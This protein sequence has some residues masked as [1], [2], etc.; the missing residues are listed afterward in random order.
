M[1]AETVWRQWGMPPAVLPDAFLVRDVKVLHILPPAD[2]K[3]HELS[4]F[5][6]ECT[7]GFIY[8]SLC[9]LGGSSGKVLLQSLSYARTVLTASI[10]TDR[11][12]KLGITLSKL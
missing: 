9:S 10:S 3:P 6:R 12:T 11:G 2:T 7:R 8:P 1:C 5:A 4:E